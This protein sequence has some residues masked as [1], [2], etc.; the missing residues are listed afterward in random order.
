[1]V[2]CE[3]MKKAQ[4]NK[5]ANIGF[6]RVTG[7]SLISSDRENY[8]IPIA[9]V[10]HHSS[11]GEACE[12][13]V[14]IDDIGDAWITPTHRMSDPISRFKFAELVNAVAAS[15]IAYDNN[16]LDFDSACDYTFNLEEAFNSNQFQS[17]MLDPTWTPG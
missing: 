15:P 3:S 9:P 4:L 1:M 6:V 7:L 2:Y 17:R 5:L 8:T 14:F 11:W 16:R 12:S 10:H 13:I